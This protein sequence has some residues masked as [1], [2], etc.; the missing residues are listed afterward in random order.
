MK[1]KT[2]FRT[3]IAL[4]LTFIPTAVSG[5]S[6]HLAGHNAAH[7]VWHNWAVAHSLVSLAFSITCAIHIYGHWAWYKSLFRN[8]LVN[9]SRITLLLSLLMLATILTG[10]IVLVRH[11][12]PL[13]DFGIWH[14]ALGIILCLIAL[15]HL[16]KRIKI[17]KNLFRTHR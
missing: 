15:G 1:A 7:S 2:L 5:I 17:L 16:I 4:I 9:K 8:G 10:N 6:L 14:F 13:T 3:D 12:G 11:Q